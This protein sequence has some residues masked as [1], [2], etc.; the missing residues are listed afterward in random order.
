MSARTLGTCRI[1]ETRPCA[2]H[3]TFTCEGC[4]PLSHICCTSVEDGIRAAKSATLE[5]LERAFEFECKRG[6]RK[7][8]MTAI[9]RQ[10]SKLKKAAILTKF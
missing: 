7:T 6:G 1:C 2:D 10:I 8:L 5:N 4:K 3:Y 9:H